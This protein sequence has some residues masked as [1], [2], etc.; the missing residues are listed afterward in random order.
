MK[1]ERIKRTPPS[2]QSRPEVQ[3]LPPQDDDTELLSDVGELLDEIDS[4]LE[5]QSVLCNFRQRSGQ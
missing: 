4:L 5:D 2:E 3:G 1:Q